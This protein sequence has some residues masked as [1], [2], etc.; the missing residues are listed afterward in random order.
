MKKYRKFK[1]AG[2]LQALQV[3]S[4]LPKI[5]FKCLS[6]LNGLKDFKCT[7]SFALLII[8]IFTPSSIDA[9]SVVLRGNGL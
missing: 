7:N 8:E 6:F 1:M 9:L 4:Y 5:N 2:F 3:K